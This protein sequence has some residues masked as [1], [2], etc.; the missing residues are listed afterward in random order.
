[1][2]LGNPFHMRGFGAVTNGPAVFISSCVQE[3]VLLFVTRTSSSSEADASAGFLLIA[4]SLV[5]T[6][7]R[8][9]L[10]LLV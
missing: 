6:H 5:S 10:R 2:G 7:H 3:G 1:M 9:V 8:R 4:F